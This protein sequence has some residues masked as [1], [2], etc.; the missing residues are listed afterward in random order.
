MS[1]SGDPLAHRKSVP[2]RKDGGEELRGTV[3]Q[4]VEF[5]NGACLGVARSSR[6]CD[7]A[8]PQ[9]VIGDE[10]PAHSQ[11]GDGEAEDFR[12]LSLRNVVEDQVEF[13]AGGPELPERIAHEETHAAE[14]TGA[15]KV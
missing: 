9:D 8:R 15:A 6:T 13:P 12:I 1:S 7:A 11:P 10:Q 3:N 4:P 2:K 14:Q 5:L